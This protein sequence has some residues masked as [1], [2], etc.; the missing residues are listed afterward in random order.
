MGKIEN[1]P[2]DWNDKFGGKI[3]Q[4]NCSRLTEI[5]KKKFYITHGGRIYFLCKW[6][7]TT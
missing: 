2:N 5:L 1:D 4:L 3:W 7:S 6:K